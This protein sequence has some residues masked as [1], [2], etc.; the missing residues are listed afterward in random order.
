MRNGR[1]VGAD[2]LRHGAYSGFV[3]DGIRSNLSAFRYW[4]REKHIGRWK[5]HVEIFRGVFLQYRWSERPKAFPKFYFLVYNSP[6]IRFS[7]V[8]HNTSIA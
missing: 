6:H 1:N 4:S 3:V 2:A 8:A 5:V 7:G